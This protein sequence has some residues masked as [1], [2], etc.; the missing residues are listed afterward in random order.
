MTARSKFTNYPP[1]LGS[2]RSARGTEWV[3]GSVPPA[4]RGNLK[5]GVVQ[6]FIFRLAAIL[7]ITVALWASA[8][9]QLK[10][11]PILTPAGVVPS[12]EIPQKALPRTQP[13]ET[14]RPRPQ[15]RDTLDNILRA[16]R[17]WETLQEE[18]RRTVTISGHKRIGFHLHDIEGDFAAFRD[19]N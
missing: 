7:G 13:A 14:P 16:L 5:E 12:I 9:A 1:P 19:Q 18:F 11:P 6:N 15:R 3:R 2:P 10:T 8:S 17:S 4:C